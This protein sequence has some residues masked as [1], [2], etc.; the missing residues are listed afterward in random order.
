MKIIVEKSKERSKS[1]YV[2]SVMDGGSV[3]KTETAKNIK[4]RDDIVFQLAESYGVDDIVIREPEKKQAKKKDEKKPAFSAI[5][6]IP[7]L[8]EEEADDFFEAN[9]ELVYDRIL[10]AVTEGIAFNRENIRLFELSG[11]GV[12]ITSRRLDWING[13]YDA[14]EWYTQADEQYEKCI[15]AKELIDKL[16]AE[17]DDSQR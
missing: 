6:S 1:L 16:Y 14:I 3:I 11:T 4:E 17:N 2:V 12:Y 7:V 13:L 5:P 15:I 9:K 10:Q 8:D